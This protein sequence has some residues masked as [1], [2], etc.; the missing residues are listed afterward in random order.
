[1]IDRLVQG[2]AEIAKA[3]VS[4]KINKQ[5]SSPGRAYF[6]IYIELKRVERDSINFL[7]WASRWIEEYDSHSHPLYPEIYD[8][9]N[10]LA[11]SCNRLYELLTEEFGYG[12]GIFDPYLEVQ[13]NKILGLKFEILQFWMSFFENKNFVES[14]ILLKFRNRRIKRTLKQSTN[15]FETEY[16]LFVHGKEYSIDE[17]Q[18]IIKEKLGYESEKLSLMDFEGIKGMIVDGKKNVKLLHEATG[19]MASFINN[20]FEISDLFKKD[21]I[22]INFDMW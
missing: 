2:L 16:P 5:T 12:L 21:D 6:L 13:L 7:M 17:L 1:M 22:R 14:K 18:N 15:E 8:S 19:N 10:N 20:K 11:A 9:L 4:V 3:L